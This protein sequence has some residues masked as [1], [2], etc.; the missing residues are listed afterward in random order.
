MAGAVAVPSVRHQG[1]SP[2]CQ[3]AA[4]GSC[5]GRRHVA[6]FDG[7]GSSAHSHHGSGAAAA[8]LSRVLHL[9][10]PVLERALDQLPSDDAAAQV[11]W[12]DAA[13]IVLR[14]LQQVQ[15]DTA[16]SLGYS[17][18]DLEFTVS[19]AIL[20]ERSIGLVQ[21]GDGCIVVEQDGKIEAGTLRQV[22]EYAG[23][24]WF[25]GPGE[26]ALQ[27]ANISLRPAAGLTAALAITDGVAHRWLHAKSSAPAPGVQRLVARLRGGEW[28]E[29]SL[30]EHLEQPWW[31]GSGDDDRSVAYLVNARPPSQF[32]GAED[33]KVNME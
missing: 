30:R 31:H 5:A 7:R 9:V 26:G 4:T 20:G 19:L 24:T 8:A 23:E 2:P 3:D 29:G 18:G 10:E 27:R 1:G 25:I 6:V 17:P 22:G 11:G 13:T 28:A 12:Q 16:L 33:R 15:A 14:A 21:V 32:A